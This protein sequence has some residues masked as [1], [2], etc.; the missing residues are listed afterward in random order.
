MCGG[1][2]EKSYNLSD[3]STNMNSKYTSYKPTEYNRL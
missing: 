2:S 1:N 3:F